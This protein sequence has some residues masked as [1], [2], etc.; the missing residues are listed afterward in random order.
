MTRGPAQLVARAARAAFALLVVAPLAACGGLP[1]PVGP[2]GIDGLTIP[3]PDPAPGDFVGRVDNRWFPLAPGTRWTYRRYTRTTLDTVVATVL[4]ASRPVDGVATTAVRYVVRRP[5]GGTTFAAVRWYAQDAAGNV[6]WFGQRVGATFPVDP[7]A[8]TSWRAGR[9]GAEAGLVMAAQPR[10]G[11]GFGNGFRAR[12][13]ERRSTVVSL[14]A[15]VTLPRGSYDHAVET[16][17]LSALAPIRVVQTYFVPGIGMV[18]QDT[19]DAV[20]VQLTLVRVSRP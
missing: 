12:D 16:R 6:W 2:S 18:A 15:S 7:L 4:P 8:T 5:S 13:M 14:D 1:T 3:T 10:V 9:N 19:T 11:D 20:D 17:D